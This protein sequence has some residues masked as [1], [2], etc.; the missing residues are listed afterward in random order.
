MVNRI[1]ANLVA[2][3]MA[4]VLAILPFGVMG[5]DPKWTQ[6]VLDETRSGCYDLMRI[7]L[8]LDVKSPKL[9]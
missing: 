7:L 8:N 5:S 2:I 4:V 3:S 1:V 6:L 9:L